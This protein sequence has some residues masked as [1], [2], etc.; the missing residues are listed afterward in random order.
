MS[1]IIQELLKIRVFLEL[2]R[3]QTM[4][5]Q[6]LLQTPVARQRS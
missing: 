5:V 4:L 2:K 3:D 6:Y 1:V